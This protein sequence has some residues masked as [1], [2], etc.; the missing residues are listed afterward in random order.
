LL[1]VQRHAVELATKVSAEA[2][3]DFNSFKNADLYIISTNDDTIENIAKNRM[4]SDKFIVH[5]S[6]SVDMSILS[7]NTDKYGVF[8]P[9]QT[10]KKGVYADF[11]KI[12]LCVEASTAEC[13]EKLKNLASE[14]S[15]NVY[16]IRSKQRLNLHIAAVFANNFSNHLYVI[17]SGIFLSK[18]KIF[19]FPPPS[20]AR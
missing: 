19:L 3:I 8:Y 12:P 11:S 9:L 5:T 4:L 17:E 20:L 16:E 13:L 15:D 14:F 18:A 2:S 7:E 6:G 1:Q 10:L